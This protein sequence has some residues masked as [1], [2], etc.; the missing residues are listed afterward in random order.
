MVLMILF[1]P[2]NKKDGET[3]EKMKIRDFSSMLS[4]WV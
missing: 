4:G 2:P 1:I 3:K